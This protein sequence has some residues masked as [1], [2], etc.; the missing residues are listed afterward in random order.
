MPKLQ[1]K[2]LSFQAGELSPRFFGRSDTDIYAK[3]LAVAE[4]VTI[5]KRGGAFKR[6]G[7]EHIGRIDANNARIF[8]LQISRTRFYTAVIFYDLILNKG[9]MLIVAPGA[10]LIGNNLLQNGNFASAGA[11]W[12]ATTEPL[13]SQVLFN[14]GFTV[15]RP[16]RN[17]IEL[18]T[19]NAFQQEGLGWIEREVPAAS[20][21]TFAVG[22]CTMIPRGQVGD[23]AG[24]AQELTTNTAGVVHTMAVTGDLGSNEV[25]VQIGTAED[26]GTYLD[27]NVNA[28]ASGVPIEFTPAASPFFITVDCIGPN[29]F[30]TLESISVLEKIT[31]TSAISQQATVIAGIGDP[32]VVIVGQVGIQELHVLI[33]TTEGASDIASFDSAE[34]EIVEVFTPNNATF[35]VT[36]L[37]DGDEIANATINFVGTAA[38]VVSFPGLGLLMDAPWSETQLDEIHAV[39]VPSG[40]ALYFTHPNVPVQKLLYD[41]LLDTFVPLTNVSFVN[42]PSQWANENWPATGTHFQGRLWLAGTP[43]EPQT[44]W[45]SKSGA[46]EHFTVVADEDSSSMEFTLQEFGRIE[47]MLGTKNLLIGAENG[48]HI[49]GSEGGVIIPTDFKIEQ[50]S[51]YGSNNMQ[52]IQVGEK[53]FYATPDGRKLRAMAYQWQED[54]WLSQ[55]LTFASEHITRGIIK[56]SVWAQNPDNLFGL[57]LESGVIIFLTYDRTAETVAWSR[58]VTPGTFIRDIATGRTSGINQIVA[59]A[60]RVVGKI[61]IESSSGVNAKLDSFS[62]V[63][64][65]GGTNVITGLDHL[66]GMT[67]RPIVDGAVNPLQVVI[68]GQI[69]TPQTGI[70]LVAGIPYTAKI[71]TL[72]PDV[73]QDQIRSWKK[74]WNKVW[75]LMYNSKAPIINGVRPPDRTPSTPMDEVEP[76]TSQHYKTVNLGWDDNGQITIEEDLPV[77]MNVLAIYG[78]M[79]T[80]SVD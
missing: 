34:H 36:V 23:I 45:G 55:D 6:G 66:E 80:E 76:N 10:S 68:G 13:S 64:D 1:R 38:E 63:F 28:L 60:Q 72:P 21:V 33:G 7:L 46:P 52:G 65:A 74:R 71:V 61:D 73:P 70:R 30:A 3:G 79:G 48:E 4:N 58:M 50:Q 35:W 44:I 24:V 25:R 42:P 32:H 15:L 78:E 20:S 29:V 57:V 62:S 27:V 16:E 43:G 41:S 31:K 5:D 77:N 26:D 39:E 54:N 56:H 8:T 17:D 14:N 2:N 11:N 59:A 49:I 19:N 69:T 53:V 47:W 67:V 75:A 22:S 9:Q 37:A 18:V 40:K 12:S 51:S